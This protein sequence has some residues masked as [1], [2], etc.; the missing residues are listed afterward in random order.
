MVGGMYK[1]AEVATGDVH[2]FEEDT[3]RWLKSIPAMP[4]G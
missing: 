1:D 3:Q 2:V 4:T